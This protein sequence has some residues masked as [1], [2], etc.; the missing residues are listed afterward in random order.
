[1]EYLKLESILKCHPYIYSFIKLKLSIQ[2]SIAKPM[3]EIF[4]L[5]GFQIFQRFIEAF[6]ISFYYYNTLPIKSNIELAVRK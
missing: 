4:L 1:M 3:K 5:K 6:Y 2:H